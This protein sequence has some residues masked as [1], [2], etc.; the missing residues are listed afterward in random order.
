VFLIGHSNGA[1]MSYRMA[2]ERSD[3]VAGIAG[4]A[5]AATVIDGW[6]CNPEQPVSILHI[7]G[8]ADTTVPY[9]GGVVQDVSP[10]AVA[11]VTEWAAH[12]GC[13]EGLID[14]DP[15]DLERTL[16]GAETTTKS[17]SCTAPVGVA[18]WT[19]VGGSHIPN[20]QPTFGV[21]VTDWLLAHS[22]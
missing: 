1:Y 20:V 10:G 15:L 22:R 21:T 4:L 7:H 2:C 18:L 6:T 14:G 11:S 5:G 3:V 13:A 17:A 12:D 9:E 19:I 16:D 8:D